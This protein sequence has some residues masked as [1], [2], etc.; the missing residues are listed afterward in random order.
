MELS[1]IIPKL[2]KKCVQ[3]LPQKVCNLKIIVH[4]IDSIGETV[5]KINISNKI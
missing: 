1:A 5:Y 4:F 3:L 2:Y